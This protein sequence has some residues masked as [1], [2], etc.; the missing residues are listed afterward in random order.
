MNLDKAKLHSLAMFFA[1]GNMA[2]TVLVL[3]SP[4]G[5][6]SG[7]GV[8]G[9][10]IVRLLVMVFVQV[11]VTISGIVLSGLSWKYGF[12]WVPALIGHILVI[13]FTFF[14]YFDQGSTVNKFIGP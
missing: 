4:F 10:S 7:S 12:Q 6:G 14:L 9:Y 8:I 5:I 11:P 1:F 3:F 13:V 2:F